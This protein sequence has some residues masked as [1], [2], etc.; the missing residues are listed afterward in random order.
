M[1]PYDWSFNTHAQLFIHSYSFIPH[2][3]CPGNVWSSRVTQT[4][5]SQTFEKLRG[6]IFK[7][8]IIIHCA[9][10]LIKQ[11]GRFGG[12]V[13]KECLG[14]ESSRENFPCNLSYFLI[15][16]RGIRRWQK[17]GR[18]RGN[19]MPFWQPVSKLSLRKQSQLP[20]C[21]I[22]AVTQGLTLVL[23]LCCRHLGIHNVF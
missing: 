9:K 6:E 5:I 23:M 14:W 21:A 10:K 19:G 22:S 18:G 1:K 20:G 2:L 16:M 7:Q 15:D 3:P 8:I 13:K 17:D 11:S 4:S 12:A